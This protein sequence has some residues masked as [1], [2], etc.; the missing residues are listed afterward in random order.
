MQVGHL[1]EYQCDVMHFVL[2]LHELNNRD[3]L[4]CE[5]A[6]HGRWEYQCDVMHFV[7]SLPRVERYICVDL[8]QAILACARW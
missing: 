3:A 8:R 5:S 2:S 4:E 6:I 7:L 1:W